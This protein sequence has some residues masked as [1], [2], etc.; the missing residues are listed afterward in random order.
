VQVIS[1]TLL[2][3]A[4]YGILEFDGQ[5]EDYAETAARIADFPLSPVHAVVGL[6]PEAAGAG[7]IRFVE[8][9]A[10]MSLLA[11][12]VLMVF[13]GLLLWL[14]RWPVGRRDFNLWINLPTF[15]PGFA[16]DAERRL[17]RDG[18][19]NIVIGILSLYIVPYASLPFIDL[20]SDD[21]QTNYQ[22]VVWS[23]VLWGFVSG[24]LIIR[25]MAVLKVWRL[26]SAAR[27]L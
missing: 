7:F 16:A 18:L 15:S 23:G 12:A 9:I 24:S 6:V 1:L 3:R 21:V 27:N 17:F 8:Y 14:I 4:D 2:C 20:T 11:S 10:A 5:I 13:F 25:G 26:V 19:A 22:L